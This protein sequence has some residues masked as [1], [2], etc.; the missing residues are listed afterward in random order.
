MPSILITGAN[1]GLGL[2]FVK[3]YAAHG[4]RIFACCRN[5]DN[6][7]TLNAVALTARAGTASLRNCTGTGSTSAAT[8]TEADPSSAD[9][10]ELRDEVVWWVKEQP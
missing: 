6:A 7:A 1:R 9:L 4:W 10:R 2:F 5:L 8:L 3:Q